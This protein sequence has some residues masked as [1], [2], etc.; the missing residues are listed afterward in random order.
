MTISIGVG[1]LTSEMDSEEKL[2][3]AADRAVYLAK[4]KKDMVW[5]HLNGLEAPA[6]QLSLDSHF[7]L[8]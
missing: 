3:D 8:V 1:T 2:L 4:G 6:A 7:E 5:P